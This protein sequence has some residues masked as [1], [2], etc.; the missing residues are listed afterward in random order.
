MEYLKV[1]L[2]KEVPQET[3]Q[4]I[5]DGMENGFVG[6]VLEVDAGEIEVSVKLEGA[7]TESVNIEENSTSVEEPKEVT[8]NVA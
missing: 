6:K 1:K 5:I 7:S 2:S 8:V 4:V 3:V